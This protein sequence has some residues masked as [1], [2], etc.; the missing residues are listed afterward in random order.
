MCLPPCC[1][2]ALGLISDADIYMS[3]VPEQLG[4]GAY[5]SLLRVGTSKTAV[6]VFPSFSVRML[7]YKIFL[8]FYL[9]SLYFCLPLALGSRA[10]YRLTYG[11]NRAVGGGLETPSGY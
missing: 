1:Q 8:R 3:T 5:L 10:V 2:L 4:G 6:I 11:S 7:P 9:T